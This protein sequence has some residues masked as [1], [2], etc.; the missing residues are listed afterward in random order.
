MLLIGPP[1]SGKT[2]FVLRRLEAAIRQGR[3]SEVKLIVPT[4]SMAQ[5]TLHTLARRDLVVPGQVVATMAD[6]VAGLTPTLKIAAAA[7]E[8]WLLQGAIRET[9]REEFAQIKNSP[10]LHAAA[11]RTIGEFWAAG[12]GASTASRFLKTPQQ[13]AFLEVFRE[14]ERRLQQAGFVHP[15]ERFRQAARRIK[16]GALESMREVFFDGFLNFTAGEHEI[17]QAV[18]DSV[19]NATVTLPDRVAAPRTHGQDSGGR[20]ELGGAADSL[21]VSGSLV[22]ADPS[23]AF[24]ALTRLTRLRRPRIRPLVIQASTPL[25]EVEEIARRIIEEKRP[26]HHYGIVLRT[27][28]QYAPPIQSVFERLQIPFRLRLPQPLAHHACARLLS[29]LLGAASK[30]FP[31]E[32][33]LDVL[34]RAASP[35]GLNRR[36]D[37]LDFRVRENLPGRGLA[38]LKRQAGSSHSLGRLMEQLEF[39]AGWRNKKVPPREWAERAKSLQESWLAMPLVSDAIPIARVLELRSLADAIPAIAQAADGAAELLEHDGVDRASLTEYLDAFES[40]LE[41]TMQQTGDQRRNVVNV[42]SIYE[43]RQWELPVV[44]VPGLVEGQFPRRYRQNLFVPDAD[45]RRL[46]GNRIHLRTTKDQDDEERFLFRIATTRAT[47]KLILSY[48][49]FDEQG[50][51]QLRSFFLKQAKEEDIPAKPVRLREPAAPFREHRPGG[52]DSPALRELVL[53]K[54]ETFAPTSLESFL[55]CPFKHFS[56]RTLKLREPPAKPEERLD[57]RVEGTIVHRTIALWSEDP[58]KQIKDVLETVLIEQCEAAS[59]PLGFRTTGA[60]CRMEADLERFAAEELARPIPSAQ[61][62]ELEASFDYLIDDT[63]QA[64]F[65]INGRIDRYEIMGENLGFVIDYKYSARDRIDKLMKEHFQGQRVQAPLY[66]IGL[67]REK[68]LRPV[69]LRYWGL[70]HKTTMRGWVVDG[71]CPPELIQKKDQRLS[72][73]GFRAMLNDALLRASD[74]IEQIRGG[75]IEADPA[76]RTVCNSYCPFRD[77]CRI[78]L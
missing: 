72:E 11:L 18:L 42:L 39:I 58:S 50:R 66:L 59:V 41:N 38:F 12:S 10:G 75:R 51:Q 56:E 32:E 53:K 70:R 76:D 33:T 60:R 1:G 15:S 34:K 40:V 35:L 3:A 69:G 67:E 7:A 27:P 31:A 29:G 49:R 77:V 13:E 74:A 17:V 22:A 43:A 62:Q 44:F 54:H 25:G 16:E 23:L 46:R 19:E 4:A 73:D 63:D 64:P 47:E 5:H 57:A 30:G 52:F 78:Q 21:G 2:H 8:A 71:L 65:R 55:Q 20:A 9:R 14:Y 61:K 45:R 36:M 28:E 37:Q 6:F 48:S 24:G 26:F 68:G